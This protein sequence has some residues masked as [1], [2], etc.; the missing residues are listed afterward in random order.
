[1]SAKA[2]DLPSAEGL[3]L[4]APFYSPLRG[5]SIT[6][7]MRRTDDGWLLDEPRARALVENASDVVTVV[8]HDLTILFV[9]DSGA[10]LLG[11]R[12]D[13]LTGTKFARLVAPADLDRLRAACGEAADGVMCRP[14]ELR[15]I[16]RDGSLIDGETVVRYD[17]GDGQLVLTT[18]DVHERKRA[19][20][21]VRRK[22][23]QQAVVAALGARALT[24][25]DLAVLMTD[26]SSGVAAALG[27]DY[28]AVHRHVP[29]RDTFTLFAAVG[30]ETARR[31]YAAVTE[32]DSQLGFTL[33]SELPVIVRDWE[34]ENRFKEA[35]FFVAHRIGSGI[36]ARIPG[37]GGP[38]GVISVQA[39]GCKR[40]NYDDGVFLQ[41][42]ANILAA[43]IARYD[44]DQK[45]RHQALHDAGTGLPNRV[46]FEDRLT[47]ALATACRHERRLAVLFL[48]LDN[49]K[50]INDSLGH[51]IGDE[52]LKSV[53]ERLSGSL[54][55]EDTLAKFG[56]DE[57][58]V[59]LPEIDDN[60]S[61]WLTVVQ[62]IRESLHEPLL[63]AGRQIITTVSIGIAV[64]G[65]GEPNKD[66]QSLVRDADLAMY[67]AKQRGPG[68]W[69]LFAEHMYEAAVR[70][71]DLTG[72]LYLAIE[73]N[74]LEVHYQPIVSL[75]DEEIVGMEALVRWSHPRHG[76]LPPPAFLPLAEESGLIIPLGRHVLRTA[77]ENL[78][79]WQQLQPRNR[80]LYVSVNFSTQEIHAPDLVSCVKEVLATTGVEPSNLMIEITEGMLLTPDDG[81]MVRLRELKD[82]GVRIAVD[83]FGTGYSALSYLSRFPIDVLKI[84]KSFIDGLGD[85]D[86][87]RLVK[88]IIELAHGV[89]L[90]TVAEGVETPDQ[91]AALR[92]LHSELGQGYHF[93]K[94]LATRDV[95]AILAPVPESPGEPVAG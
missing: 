20:R 32:E 28:V 6:N 39:T 22:A 44:G 45:I 89:N 3:V 34:V 82:L 26:A 70:R 63:T 69:E 40:F 61:E 78:K 8:G 9:T 49:F 53:A 18:R 73:R 65:A 74:E 81:V 60:G 66:A 92:D 15:L 41:A 10:K 90:E 27:A 5:R 76:L 43:A 86:Q 71:L 72:D 47:L 42:I 95:D 68:E 7:G 33:A 14:V 77:C 67:A 38:F 64:G 16:H 75:E 52:V 19:E 25:D 56:G 54:R 29:D 85:R 31:Y 37:V 24:C 93:A 62:R 88:G 12:A 79:R 84:D 50:R 55:A 35:P 13:E 30:L 87:D 17:P 59:L 91:A 83:D 36:S 48:D 11:Y 57:F 21:Q 46:L 2:P 1:M 51:A 80:N 94:P 58:V 4:G 23:E